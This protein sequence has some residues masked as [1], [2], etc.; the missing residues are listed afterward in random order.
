MPSVF[1]C[2]LAALI[3]PL[4]D[5]VIIKPALKRWDLEFAT[6][7]ERAI[8]LKQNQAAGWPDWQHEPGM[9]VGHASTVGI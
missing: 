9:S 3:P 8:A 2:F 6:A 4:W 5:G 1:I 7:E